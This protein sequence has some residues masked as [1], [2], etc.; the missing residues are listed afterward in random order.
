M[1]ELRRGVVNPSLYPAMTQLSMLEHYSS[2][3]MGKHMPPTPVSSSFILLPLLLLLIRLL[4]LLLLLLPVTG[5]RPHFCEKNP[6]I[7]ARG[8]KISTSVKVSMSVSICISLSL[9]VSLLLY[10]FVAAS[11]APSAP[12]RVSGYASEA[13]KRKHVYMHKY[14]SDGFFLRLYYVLLKRDTSREVFYWSELPLRGNEIGAP[15]KTR[16]RTR[17]TRC[18]LI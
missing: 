8:K 14:M 16:S 5:H 3:N 12:V 4:L 18:S 7:Y 17:M 2:S 9:C 15:H 6:S 11:V 1:Q 10:T 13:V